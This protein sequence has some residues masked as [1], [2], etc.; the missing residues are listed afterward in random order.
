MTVK[1]DW[2]EMLNY[3]VKSRNTDTSDQIKQ[4]GKLL[5]DYMN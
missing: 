1:Q 3:V 4:V 5:N 2:L